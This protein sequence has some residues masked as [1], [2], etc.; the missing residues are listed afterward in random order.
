LSQNFSVVLFGFPVRFHAQ[1][2]S[3]PKSKS[4]PFC[5]RNSLLEVASPPETAQ[6]ANAENLPLKNTNK[7]KEESNMNKHTQAISN[8]MGQ[9]AEDARALMAA[10]ADVAGEKVGEA[11]KRLAASLESAK[12]IAGRVRDKA[13]E[14]AKA[15]DETVRE[16]PYQAMGIAFGVGALI[17]CLLSRRCSRNGDES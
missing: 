4:Q 3:F 11:R 13:L 17:G 7:W 8:D 9:L 5:E 1:R 16:N 15:A 2:N 12:E 6:A 14:G 10:T